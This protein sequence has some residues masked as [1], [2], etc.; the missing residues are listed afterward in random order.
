MIDR[1][2][3]ENGC[4]AIVMGTRG[5]SALGNLALGSVAAKVVHLV[6]EYTASRVRWS[7]M[8]DTNIPYKQ[9]LLLSC[10]I[11]S[12]KPVFCRAQLIIKKSNRRKI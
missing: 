7:R 11:K 5:M 8:R 6:D 3:R 1:D 2:A 4:D 10:R 12:I 9:F